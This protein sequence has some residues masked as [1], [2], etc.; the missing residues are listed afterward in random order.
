MFINTI[1]GYAKQCIQQQYSK[2]KLID[3]YLKKRKIEREI[4]IVQ[5][6]NKTR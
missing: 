1:C 6:D 2:L 5:C 4:N 3:I